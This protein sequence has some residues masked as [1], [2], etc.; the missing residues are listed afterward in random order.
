M[1]IYVYKSSIYV[2]LPI[3]VWM[4]LDGY[5]WTQVVDIHGEIVG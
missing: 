1:N 5:E 3:W 2:H 4:H